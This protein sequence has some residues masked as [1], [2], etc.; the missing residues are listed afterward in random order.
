L[1]HANC[2][3]EIA[4][5]KKE[6]A[7]DIEEIAQRGAGD[8]YVDSARNI[9]VGMGVTDVKDT[10]QEFED[11]S[12]LLNRLTPTDE[13]NIHILIEQA[14]YEL[15]QHKPDQALK[16]INAGLRKNMSCLP[17]QELKG[18]CYIAMNRYREALEAADA[19]LSNPY[20]LNWA[21]KHGNENSTA[22]SVKAYA[23]YNLGDFE[24]ALLSFHRYIR[25][26][27]VKPKS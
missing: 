27:Y 3:R 7:R 17:M 18:K 9:A 14:A 19:I 5:V 4:K 8:N 13:L 12:S 21:R 22:L 16:F 24:H 23:L 15:R 25:I 10:L 26:A 1:S 11:Q 20:N 6:K 2:C